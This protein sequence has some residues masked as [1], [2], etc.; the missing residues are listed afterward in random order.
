MRLVSRSGL[1]ATALAVVA[2]VV[3]NAQAV[4]F[5]APPAS[6]PSVVTPNQA[7][8]ARE[9]AGE[10]A[11]FDRIAQAYDRNIAPTTTLVVSTGPRLICT[12]R[13]EPPVC[14]PISTLTGSSASEGFQFGDAA[15]GAGVMVGLTL[16]GAAG[17]VMVRPRSE[18][19][20]P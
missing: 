5:Y 12:P 13:S 17:A 1:L 19:H 11:A 2:L 16:L 4:R 18:L 15:I 10:S 6:T 7:A 8:V 14:R 3:P 20:Q 9:Q